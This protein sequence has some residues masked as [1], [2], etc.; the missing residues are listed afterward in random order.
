MVLK[1][2]LRCNIGQYV[3]TCHLLSVQ[4]SAIQVIKINE[5]VKQM[6]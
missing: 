1:G 4:I 3:I 2:F 6:F 5:N